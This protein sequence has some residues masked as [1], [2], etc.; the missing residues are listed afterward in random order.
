MKREPVDE[1]RLDDFTC[2]QPCLKE[3]T[4]DDNL[5][6]VECPPD[7]SEISRTPVEPLGDLD[8]LPPELL[9][10]VLSKLDVYTLTGFRRVNRQ[11]LQAVETIPQYKAVIT[12]APTVLH[13]ILSIEAG[14][15]ISCENLYE[16]LCTAE[17]E[18]CGDFA[19]YLYILTCSRVCFCCLSGLSDNMRYLPLL[20]S[21][22]I[23]KFGLSSQI[24]HTLPSMRSIPGIY[25]PMERTSR[26]RFNL[27]DSESACL[28]SIALHGSSS[29]MEQYVS[30][31]LDQELQ[32]SS[33]RASQ[34]TD[35]ESELTTPRLHRSL[36]RYYFDEK[37]GNPLRFMAIVRMP[38]LNKGSW[39]LEW[40]VYCA[41]CEAPYH[42]WS[43]HIPRKFTTATIKKHLRRCEYSRDRMH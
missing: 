30:Q 10:M 3:F 14:S 16:T 23:E 15:W 19:G 12:H 27:V 28:A 13:A 22:A 7:E 36:T 4:L 39:E 34:A 18:Q 20:H 37:F 26:G 31:K 5:T 29:A 25:S 24:L 35:E 8:T 42:N 6:A 41:G 43:L 1:L 21:H 9:R 2:A 11:A 32:D 38:W 40:G 17:C 33:K